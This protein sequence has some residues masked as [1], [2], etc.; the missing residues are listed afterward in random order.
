MARYFERHPEV[1][2]VY[3]HRVLVDGQDDRRWAGGSCP[4]PRRRHCRWADYVPQ[5]T[6]FWRRRMWEAV[7]GRDR[8]GV[9][10]R[11]V[12]WDL[13]LRFRDVGARMSRV[14]RFLG[15]AR[16]DDAVAVNGV[17]E[18]GAEILTVTERGESASGT[19]DAASADAAAVSR[20]SRW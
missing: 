19:L 10:L 18:S 2:V 3:G 6:L 13:L 20:G 7:G 17:T 9:P 14:P 8:R 15:A 1:D 4:A 11:P 16:I 5:E 12:D